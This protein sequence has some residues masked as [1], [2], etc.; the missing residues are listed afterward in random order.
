MEMI[1]L[2]ISGKGRILS[3]LRF[4]GCESSLHVWV[5]Q[6]VN[7]MN[8]DSHSLLMVYVPLVAIS[9]ARVDITL[10]EIIYECRI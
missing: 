10:R 3:N 1:Y 7:P 2:I 5:N 9:F 4:L 8:L 6:Y